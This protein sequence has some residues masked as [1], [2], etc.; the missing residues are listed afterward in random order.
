[1]VFPSSA[2]PAC[3]AERPFRL[4]TVLLLICGVLV[5]A[6]L[7]VLRYTPEVW[8]WR[9]IPIQWIGAARVP[10]IVAQFRDP[11]GWSTLA[12]NSAEP[13][14]SWRLLLPLAGHSLHLTTQ[15][16]LALPWVG[17]LWLLFLSGWY[18]WKLSG[19]WQRS[20][21]A[22][23]FVATSAP[24]FM[25]TICLGQYEV[26]AWVALL[27]FA[28]SRSFLVAALACLLG[29]WIDERFLLILPLGAVLRAR[30]GCAHWWQPALAILPYVL[31]RLGVTAMGSDQSVNHHLA[32]QSAAFGGYIGAVPLGWWY[33]FR[34]AWI[35]IAC[36]AILCWQTA[37]RAERGVL[38]AGGLGLAAI[39]FLAWDSTRSIA[40]LVGLVVFGTA[41]WRWS[42]RL[43][44]IAL[45]LNFLLP[46]AF[47]S[48]IVSP[49]QVNNVTLPITSFLA[50]P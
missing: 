3:Q 46:A 27:G 34:L 35:A 22:M 48:S 43:L 47:V 21:L 44:W 41:R 28:F 12:M 31:I 4:S 18:A 42:L 24:W 1:M 23:A 6:G 10:A 19:S 45:I 50:R 25:A 33:G 20:V 11:I 15:Q 49:G 9:G 7:S 5:I 30:S 36:A 39:V 32:L 14:L 17:A 29:P 37:S 8:F 13:A 38:L 26:F 16:Y 40:V 2:D